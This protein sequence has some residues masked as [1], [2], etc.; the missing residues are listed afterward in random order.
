MRR[1]FEIVINKRDK[2]LQVYKLNSQYLNPILL[3]HCKFLSS[4]FSQPKLNFNPQTLTRSFS[5]FEKTRGNGKLSMHIKKGE[6]RATTVKAF[7]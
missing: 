7:K 4:F 5:D 1:A 6:R 3:S 2:R